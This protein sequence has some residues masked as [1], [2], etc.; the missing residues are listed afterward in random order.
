VEVTQSGTGDVTR[1]VLLLDPSVPRI[2]GLFTD[3]QGGAKGPGRASL[4]AGDTLRVVGYRWNE[5][6]DEVEELPSGVVLTVGPGGL[7]SLVAA[8]APPPSGTYRYGVV[9]ED[10][11]G[12]DDEV[13]VVV[14]IP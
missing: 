8:S 7:A 9:V 4:S 5:A 13:S 10:P 11:E 6:A 1:A 2:E 14:T 3:A 12:H